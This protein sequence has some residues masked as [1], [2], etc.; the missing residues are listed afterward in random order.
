MSKRIAPLTPIDSMRVTSEDEEEDTEGK[1]TGRA[2]NV[3]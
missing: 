3:T 1:S 2:T